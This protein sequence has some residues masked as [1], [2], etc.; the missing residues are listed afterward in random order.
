MLGRHPWTTRVLIGRGGDF[1]HENQVA[2]LGN[3]GQF[4][5]D[6]PVESPAEMNDGGLG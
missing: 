3:A 4:H 1:V 6:K 5:G 2:R